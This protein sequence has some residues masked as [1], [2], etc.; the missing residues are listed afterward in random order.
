MMKIGFI[1]AGNMAG[2]IIRGMTAGGF[3]GGDILAYDVDHSRMLPLFEECGI[4]LCA[5]AEEAAESCDA[6][7]LAVKPQTLPAVLP[8]LSPALHRRR[9][10]VISIAAGKTMETFENLMGGGLPAVR[11]MPNL[12]ARVGEAMSAFCANELVEDTQKGIVRLIFES[13]GEIVELEERLFPIFS[14]LSGCSPAYSLLYM[15]A[16]AEAGV[17]GGLSKSVAL[18]IAA[19]AVMGTARL[20]QETGEHPR[21]LADQVCSP[22]GTTIEGVCALQREGFEA[23]VLAAARASLDRDLQL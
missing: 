22:A 7:V 20:L 3:H 23:A 2:A 15:D 21:A 14:V 1:G 10:L 13:V 8:P 12:N 16:L 6:L 9:P 17:R 18:K 5:S 4:C 11:V 19:Q